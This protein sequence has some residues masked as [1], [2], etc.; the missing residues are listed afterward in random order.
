M[1][2]QY[3]VLLCWDCVFFVNNIA[4]ED[5]DEKKDLYE[6]ALSEVLE[7]NQDDVKVQTVTEKNDGLE[8]ISDCPRSAEIPD[9][10]ADKLQSN[11][12]DDKPLEN[13]SAKET[14]EQEEP[15]PGLI[16]SICQ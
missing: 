6:K 4:K 8:V 2:C 3:Y 14:N 13:I 12:E 11:L 7:V 15:Y 9:D 16:Y 10:A 1:I 5:F